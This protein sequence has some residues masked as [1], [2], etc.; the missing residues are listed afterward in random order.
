MQDRGAEAAHQPQ[1]ERGVG[2][3][4]QILDV[5]DDSEAGADGKPLHRGVDEETDAAPGNQHHDER[6]LHRFLGDRRHVAA[7]GGQLEAAGRQEPAVEEEARERGEAAGGDGRQHGPDPHQLEAVH[8]LQSDEEQQHG[9]QGG[10]ER[11]SGG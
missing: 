6:G 11:A 2:Q 4:P 5:L 8:Q 9:H 3:R 1:H 10:R 7:E